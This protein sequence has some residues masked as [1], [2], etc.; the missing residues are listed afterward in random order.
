[1]TEDAPICPS[2]GEQ[3]MENVSHHGE[4]DLWFCDNCMSGWWIIRY[5]PTLEIIVSVKQ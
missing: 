5:H 2:C 1:M 4:I 3:N